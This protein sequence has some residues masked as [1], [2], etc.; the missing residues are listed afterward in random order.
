MSSVKWSPHAESL[1]EEIVLG[2]ANTLYPDAG[3]RWERKLREA[4]DGLGDFPLSHPTIPVECYHIV[5]PNPERL[6]LL[7]VKPY[8][9]VYEIV[10]SE[11]HILSIRHG[12]MLVALNDTSWH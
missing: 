8:R 3:I 12:R 11:V 6:H 5:P 10:D 4:A 1:L 2:I 7:I 9:I